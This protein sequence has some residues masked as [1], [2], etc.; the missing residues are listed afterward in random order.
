ML[1]ELLKDT[2]LAQSLAAAVRTADA[3]G[4]GV[5]LKGYESALVL[6]LVGPEGDTPSGSVTISLELEESD[7][8]STYTDVAAADML[9]ESPAIAGAN[10]Q[11][12]LVDDA[13]EAPIAVAVAYLGKKRYLRVV[14]NRTGTHTNG[15]L[16]WAGVL[17]GHPR[18]APV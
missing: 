6:A 17:R 8:D 15:T 9:V 13:A 1:R 2:S 12:L 4:T 11:F 18:S 3:N 5:D 7:D 14:D 10:G 16:T